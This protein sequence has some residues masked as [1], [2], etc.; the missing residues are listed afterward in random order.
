MMAKMGLNGKMD[1]KA[2]AN[3]MQQH[4]KGSKTKERLQK[5]REMN[6]KEREKMKQNESKP[7]DIQQKND[8]TFVVKIG[9]APQKSSKRKNKKKKNKNQNQ[10]VENVENVENENNEIMIEEEK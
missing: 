2:M 7:V 4:M 5:K 3:K 8:D 6:T 9:D 1:F 10:N